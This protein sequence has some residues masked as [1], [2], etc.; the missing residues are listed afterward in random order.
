MSAKD[1]IHDI[2]RTALE[3]DG[4]RITHDPLTIR[5]GSIR[6][7]ADLGAERLL[8]AEKGTRKIAVEIKSFVGV[9]RMED[10]QKAIGQY[11]LYAAFLAEVEPEREVY[12]AVSDEIFYTLFDSVEGQVIIRRV[13]L[14]ILAVNL[15]SQEVVLWNE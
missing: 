8:A 3:K 9:S 15:N 13:S 11:D 14:K 10:L 1:I 5:F 12:L 7:F 4:W 6:L 2:V